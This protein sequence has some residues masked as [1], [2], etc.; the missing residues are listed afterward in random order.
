VNP[1]PTNALNTKGGAL[2]YTDTYFYTDAGAHYELLRSKW[3][4]R[5][6]RYW[7]EVDGRGNVVALTDIRRT[8]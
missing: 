4:R 3:E 8:S 5:H 2:L 7:Y 1:A 6:Q